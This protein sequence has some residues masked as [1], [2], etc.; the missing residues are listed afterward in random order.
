MYRKAPVNCIISVINRTLSISESIL[1]NG[2]SVNDVHHFES[3]LSV[4]V[5]LNQN[6]S[7]INW[8]IFQILDWFFLKPF[9]LFSFV[10][11]NL[12]L[13]NR[14]HFSQVFNRRK[15]VSCIVYADDVY[16][17][18]FLQYIQQF[19]TLLHEQNKFIMNKRTIERL[20]SKKN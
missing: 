19:A 2:H 15:K 8:N 14:S 18:F 4:S 3:E 1:S 5:L 10:K 12:N 13:F 6:G 9:Y 16:A 17:F 11:W 7:P 20:K